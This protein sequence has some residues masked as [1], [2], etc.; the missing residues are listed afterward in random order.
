MAKIG[1]KKMEDLTTQK[2][3]GCSQ[4]QQETRIIYTITRYND[5][6]NIKIA[7]YIYNLCKQDNVDSWTMI[8]QWCPQVGGVW[9]SMVRIEPHQTVEKKDMP[10][11][12]PRKNVDVDEG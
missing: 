4:V 3:G 5:N 9:A 10:A 8:G 2:G 1:L 11:A 12:S 6:N 7:I